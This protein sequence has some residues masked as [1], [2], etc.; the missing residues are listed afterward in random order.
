MACQSAVA[1][2]SSC[3]LAPKRSSL[4]KLSSFL[5]P[6]SFQGLR[7]AV[8]VRSLRHAHK[9]GPSFSPL[10]SAPS[11]PLL[12]TA[13]ER[14]LVGVEAP[15]F[16]AEAVLDQEFVKVLGIASDF[17]EDLFTADPITVQILDAREQIWSFTQSRVTDDMCCHLLAPFTVDE[18]RDAVHSLAPASC[19]GDDGLTRGFFV[20]H[21][22]IMHSWLLR[23]CQDIFTSG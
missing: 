1:T 5:S 18:L 16:E 6:H 14:P 9:K 21:W 3:C 12:V 8:S 19:P 4:P 22:E 2:S 11:R 13:G 7:R 23:G 17:Y 20:T 15:D 10:T